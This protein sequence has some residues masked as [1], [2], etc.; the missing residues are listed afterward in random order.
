MPYS[1]LSLILIVV[2][3]II[4]LGGVGGTR[5]GV[6]LGYGGGPYSISLITVLLVVVIVLALTGKL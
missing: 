1:P 2:L 6:P 5:W 4:L 3:V